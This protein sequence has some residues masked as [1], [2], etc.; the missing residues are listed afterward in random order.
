MSEPFLGEIRII[1]FSFAPRGWA[2]CNG[3]L[4]PISQ[5]TALFSILG[6]YFGGDGKVTFGLPNL[7]G[8]TP[9]SQGQG[10]GLTPRSLGEEGGAPDVT[11]TLKEMPSHNHTIGCSSGSGGLTS[12][13]NADW[14]ATGRGRPAPYSPSGQ[15]PM[16]NQALTFAGG[17]YPHNNMSPYLGLYFVIALKGIFPPR[18]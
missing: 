13:Q 14:A 16:S 8:H 4:L 15:T 9:I 11:L 1:G 7:Q 18:S 2:I 3:Q 12:P 6:T 10:R 5:N 17:G